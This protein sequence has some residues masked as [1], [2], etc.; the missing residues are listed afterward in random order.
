MCKFE[1]G[2]ALGSILKLI[3]PVWVDKGKQTISE[4]CDTSYLWKI[5]LF[6]PSFSLN[7]S[8]IVY[9]HSYFPDLLTLGLAMWLVLDNWMLVAIIQPETWNVFALLSLSFCSLVHCHEKNVPHIVTV[10]W[11]WVSEWD[12]WG[13]PMLWVATGPGK[14]RH[15]SNKTGFNLELGAWGL[16]PKAWNLEPGYQPSPA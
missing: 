2:Q 9:S 14:I 7:W 15:V 1:G 12:M 5:E 11:S 4:H 3:S 13:S 16:E 8:S 10:S 6:V